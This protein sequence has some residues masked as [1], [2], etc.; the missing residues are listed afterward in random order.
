MYI[1]IWDSNTYF[2]EYEYC[3]SRGFMYFVERET[4]N[5]ILKFREIFP[6][7]ETAFRAHGTNFFFQIHAIFLEKKIE[8][9]VTDRY[10][11]L[12]LKGFEDFS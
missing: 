11:S 10:L 9:V 3:Y 1:S 6:L 2:F 8:F 4:W 12:F 5:I 7:R